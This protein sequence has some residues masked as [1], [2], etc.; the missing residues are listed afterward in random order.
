MK[1]KIYQIPLEKDARRLAFMG[2]RFTLEH[3]GVDPREYELVF[4]GEIE[5]KDLEDV[6]V[7]FNNYAEMPADYKGRSLSVSDVVVTDRGAFF[8][9]TYGFLKLLEWEATV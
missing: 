5:A 2:M 3:G 6:Y 4:E 7:I 1:L 8:C 9:D